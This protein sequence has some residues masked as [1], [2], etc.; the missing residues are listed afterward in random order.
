[1]K[2]FLFFA[3]SFL[4]LASF[5]SYAQSAKTSEAKWNGD[6]LSCATITVDGSRDVVMNNLKKAL[7]SEKLKV[8]G[9]AKKLQANAVN[10]ARVSKNLI[11]VYATSEKDG[12][13]QT[14][15]N[16]FL[17]TG[18][19][20]DTFIKDGDEMDNLKAFLENDFAPKNEKVIKD[21]AE[22]AQKK[23]EK[24]KQKEIK[25]KEK[26]IKKKQE[27]LKNLKKK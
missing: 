18:A 13:N 16:V 27:E 7:K 11:N 15:V 17:A 24:A 25:K 2:R 8:S 19:T 22:K 6:K 26:E 23:A 9:N 21:L 1:M 20:N 3:L 12:D 10:W 5:N 4:F 14:T